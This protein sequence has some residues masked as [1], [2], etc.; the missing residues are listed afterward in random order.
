M[1]RIPSRN[2]RPVSCAAAIFGIAIAFLTT[3]QAHAQEPVILAIDA[4]TKI[5]DIETVCTG[6]GLDARQD[7]RWGS[8]ALKVEIAGAGGRYLGDEIISLRQNGK[9]L[10][11][12][13][14][15][16]P[17]VL[18]AIP[19]GRYEVEA[20]IGDRTIKSAAFVSTEGQGRV[21]L[22]VP[23]DEVP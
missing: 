22:R 1:R 13:R 10:L 11:T 19:V 18:F 4:P 6:I 3:L 14:C 21:I 5:A 12:A 7:P 15:A 20:Q 2:A 17:W 16:G 8:Y 23:E 9:T